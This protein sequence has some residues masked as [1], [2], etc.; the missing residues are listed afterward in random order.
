MRLLTEAD[1]QAAI[2]PGVA[3][4][5]AREAYR[6][7][8]AGE[9]GPP[10]R[11]EIAR[12]EPTAGALT[13]VGALG[14]HLLVKSNVH[15][16]PDGG[17]A[18][19]LWGGL[20][21]LWDLAAC[22]PR[23]LI[24]GRAFHD[25]RTAAGYAAAADILAA[26]E[27]RTL[28][29]FGA[30]KTAPATLRYLK[31]VRPGLERVALVGRGPARVRAFAEQVASWPDF[32]GVAVVVETDGERAVQ[33]A[34]IV[35]TVTSSSTP[36]FP[37][38]AVRPGALVVLGGANKPGMR[39]ADD[40]LMRRA[41]VLVDA[42]PGI[43]DKAGDLAE[44]LR[45]GALVPERIVAEIGACLDRPPPEAPGADVTVFKSVGLAVQDLLLALRLVEA[46]ERQGR[47]RLL[48]LEGA[49]P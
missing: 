34:D 24:A 29:L 33:D 42:R 35:V 7:Q 19:R 31:R 40:E 23:A 45:S 30:G 22:R 49:G 2:D 27:A 4:A 39:E 44:A 47:G 38:R 12:E 46:A 20:L 10:V 41:R 5:A 17:A 15:A 26:S 18:P 43:L 8:A 9:V 14:P 37:G 13:L 6:L 1:I 32:A 3:I 36:V 48:D 11:A 28:A 21:T 25:H 16:W